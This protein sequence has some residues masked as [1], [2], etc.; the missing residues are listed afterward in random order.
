MT[1]DQTALLAKA[2]DSI[3]GAELLFRL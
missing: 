3:R 1:D 2:R